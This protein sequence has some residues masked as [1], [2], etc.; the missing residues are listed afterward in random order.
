MSTESKWGHGWLN[1]RT[2]RR[3]ASWG[4]GIEE[5]EG[6]LLNDKLDLFWV[7]LKG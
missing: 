6:V 3:K 1:K 5:F 4:G 2:G 7:A